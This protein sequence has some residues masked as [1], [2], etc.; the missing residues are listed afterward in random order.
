MAE[1][2]FVRCE[3]CGSLIDKTSGLD[4]AYGKSLRQYV[5]FGCF[6]NLQ[7][8]SPFTSARVLYIQKCCTSP[9]PPEH[10]ARSHKVTGTIVTA[11]SA[12]TLLI[13]LFALFSE[14]LS[15]IVFGIFAGLMLISGIRSIQKANE[16]EELIEAKSKSKI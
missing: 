3:K 9:L 10:Q 4:W 12:F 14:P 5:C 16:M 2:Y 7:D 8:K 15:G 13:S 6:T 11:L 1:R